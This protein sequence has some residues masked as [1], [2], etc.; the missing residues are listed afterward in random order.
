MHAGFCSKSSSPRQVSF[1][2]LLRALLCLSLCLLCCPGSIAQAQVPEYDWLP[3]LGTAPLGGGGSRSTMFDVDGTG[4]GGPVPVI[5]VGSSLLALIDGS[6]WALFESETISGVEALTTYDPDGEGPQLP[7]LIAG[8]VFATAGGVAASRIARWD[9][10]TWTSLGSGMNNRVNDLTIY[11][12]DGTGPQPPQLIAGGFFTTAGGVAANRIA[13][14]DG[15]TWAPLGSGMNN[16]VNSLTIFDPDNAGPQPA[17][18]IATGTFTTAGGMSANQIARWDGTT[19]APLG[20]GINLTVEDMITYDPDGSG[21]QLPQLIAA[22][23][24]TNAGGVAANRIARW[25]GTTWAPLGS[26]MNGTVGALTT[27]DPDGAGPQP[28]QLIAAGEFFTAGGESANQIARWDGTSWAPLGSGVEYSDGSLFSF[29]PDG[30]GPQPAQLVVGGNFTIDGVGL[31]AYGFARW[32]GTTWDPFRPGMNAAVFTVNNFDPDGSG[33]LSAQ[34]MAGGVFTIAGGAT[35]N[36]I[37]R[38]DGTTWVPLGS[39]MNSAVWALANYD[40]DG[41][42]PLS[43]QLIAGGGF[44]TAGG[45]TANRIARWNGTTWAPLASGFNALVYALTT[46][47][48][49]GTGPQ[50]PQLIAAGEFTSAGVVTTNRIARWD[51]TTW[52]PLGGGISTPFGRVNAVTAYDPDGSGLRPPQLIAAGEFFT[53]GGEAANCIARWDGTTWAPLGSGMND[54][55]FALT[56]Y[57]LDGAGPQPPQL[58]AGGA[59]TTAGGVLAN[60]IARWDGTTWASLG[61]EMNG[62]VFALATYDPDGSGPLSA[63]L[64]AGGGFTTAGG[65][66]ANRIARWDGTTWVPLRSGMNNAVRALANYDPDGFGPLPAQLIAGGEFGRAGRWATGFIAAYG[67]MGSIPINLDSA[68]LNLDGAFDNNDFVLFIQAF[69]DLDLIADRG[70]EGASR[71]PDGIFDINDF[72]VFI[73]QFFEGQHP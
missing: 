15:T 17:Q 53:A 57:D 6:S 46:Y 55:V 35:S 72:V 16:R 23:N 26:G 44:T 31:S 64:I 71:I 62:A 73:Q 24:F 4:P 19:W 14:W 66:T 25:D 63:Q 8:G 42:G 27:Y 18:L 61:S 45:V 36:C 10:T 67:Q 12:P 54:R 21:P 1:R 65:V 43:A 22:G 34:L 13:R 49:D 38:W 41:S 52:A 9:G 50:P 20:S 28:P 48:P 56:T 5:I 37:A 68:D 40:P 70:S 69:F 3:T 58:I 32:N 59:F 29:D 51:G 33:P 7:Q 47:D 11:D 60:R 2:G 39:G 30:F